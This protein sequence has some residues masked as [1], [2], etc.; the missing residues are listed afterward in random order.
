M[1]KD[2]NIVKAHIHSLDGEMDV[3][4]I[5]KQN[6][7]NDIQAIYQEKLC[8]AMINSLNGEYYVDDKYGIIE[9][10]KLTTREKIQNSVEKEFDDYMNNM[11]EKDPM[12]IF[13]KSS[14]IHAYTEIKECLLDGDMDIL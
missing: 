11:I 8:T 1:K 5:V 4:E 6:S 7:N 12:E 9:I 14:E 2:K 3:V 13:S 10:I